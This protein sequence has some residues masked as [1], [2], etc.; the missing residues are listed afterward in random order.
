[1]WL[2]P[3]FFAWQISSMCNL[4]TLAPWEVRHL[5][6]HYRLIGTDFEEVMRGRNETLDVYPNRPAPV[7]IEQDGQRIV[8]Q[9][10]LWG[11]PP[12]KPGAGYGTNF[13]TLKNHLWRGWL[14]REHRCVVPA[15]AFAEPDRNTSKPVVWRWFERSDKQP[16]FFAGIWRPWTGDR[17][18]KKKPNIGDHALFSIMTTE[19]NAIVEPIH[20]KA[21]PVMLMTPEDVEQWLHGVSVDDALTMQKSAPD[22]A[23]VIRPA[24]KKAA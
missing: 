14:D 8:R 1:L 11:F 21:M 10:M 23:I 5:I 2:A 15:T 7:V 17:G 12:F 4:Y 19:P 9:D 24:E 6:Q 18:S 13:R 20:E 22:D 3:I 16:F